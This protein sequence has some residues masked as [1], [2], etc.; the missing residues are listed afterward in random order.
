[1]VSKRGLLSTSE[2]SRVYRGTYEGKDVAIEQ[3]DRKEIKLD[4]EVI[5]KR[6]NHPWVVTIYNNFENEDYYFIVTELTDNFENLKERLRKKGK[7]DEVTTRALFKLYFSA[8]RALN[9]P[10]LLS[11]IDITS[12]NVI[13]SES[14]KTLKLSN[15]Y[16]LQDTNNSIATIL[17]E[18]RFAQIPTPET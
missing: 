11:R 14:T 3:I 17:F 10:K 18:M 6:I 5:K 7:F 15:Y 12:K 2:Y 13:Y 4:F 16:I 9:N 8:L 1:M